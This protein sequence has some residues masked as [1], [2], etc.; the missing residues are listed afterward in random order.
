MARFWWWS[1]CFLGGELF[2]LDQFSR[3]SV[4]AGIGLLQLRRIEETPAVVLAQALQ[5]RAW[6]WIFEKK[7]CRFG[8]SEVKDA[9][10][11]READELIAPLAHLF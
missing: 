7:R 1:R 8:G 3:S 6:I 2:K 5:D 10:P 11:S 9:I 4:V